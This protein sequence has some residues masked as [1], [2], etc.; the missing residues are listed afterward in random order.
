MAGTVVV[1][2]R[3]AGAHYLIQTGYN[4]FGKGPNADQSYDTDLAPI[5]QT[6]HVGDTVTWQLNTPVPHAVSFCPETMLKAIFAKQARARRRCRRQDA[7]GAQPEDRRAGRWP[8]LRRC[9]LPQ[10]R[11][12]LPAAGE[13]DQLHADLHQAWRLLCLR[14]VQPLVVTAVR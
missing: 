13:D 9:R 14:L 11:G 6:I 10:L 8:H 1:A 4:D 3:P 5:E 7:P 2:P 12:A